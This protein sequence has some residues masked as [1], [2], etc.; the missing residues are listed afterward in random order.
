[1]ERC[2]ATVGC[3][4]IVAN[5]EENIGK[6]D[7]SV[8]LMSRWGEQK[9]LGRMS[10]GRLA[11]RIWHAFLTRPA[12]AFLA[13]GT[14]VAAV[15]NRRACFTTRGSCLRSRARVSISAFVTT[16]AMSAVAPMVFVATLLCLAR[17]RTGLGRLRMIGTAMA[18]T[19]VPRL[20]ILVTADRKLQGYSVPILWGNE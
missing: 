16:A 3:R 18:R 2:L 15:G 8:T 7:G 12:A 19:L 1:M 13:R 20:A 17:R 4:W 11:E 14:R 5:A 9:S 10:K 6:K